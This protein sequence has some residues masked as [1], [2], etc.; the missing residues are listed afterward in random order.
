VTTRARRAARALPW[1]LAPPLV[2]ACGGRY[3]APDSASTQGDDVLGLWRWLFW[4]A[5]FVG[6]VVLGLILFAIVRY[7]RRGDDDTLPPQTRE[8]VPIELFY[9]AVPLVIVA[10]LFGISV[11]TQQ[12]VTK[13]SAHP[14]VRVEV[15]GFQWQWRFRYPRQGITIVGDLEHPP[16]LVLPVGRTTRLDLASSDVVHSFYVPAF[17]EKRDLVPGVKNEIDVHPT[18]AGRFAGHCAEFCGLAHDRM[19]FDVRTLAPGD[20]ARWVRAQQ[21]R[22]AA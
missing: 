3:G 1:L 22:P 21:T 8:H 20:F 11:A 4:T 2:A 15:T 7:R 5:A 18:R 10:V 9:T 13:L 17:L 16:T 6:A 19:G 12:R 14:D